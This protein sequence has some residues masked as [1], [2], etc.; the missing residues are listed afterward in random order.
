[1]KIRNLLLAATL[2]LSLAGMASAQVIS[3]NPRT[4]DVSVDGELCYMND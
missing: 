4:G 2:G 1:M 3:Y